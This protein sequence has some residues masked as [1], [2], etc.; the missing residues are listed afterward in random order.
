MV[1]L[2][3]ASPAELDIIQ[4]KT[5][6]NLIQEGVTAE[7]GGIN[8]GEA[9]SMEQVDLRMYLVTESDQNAK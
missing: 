5:A 2:S 3:P 8:V 9:W 1:L 6:S 4:L 7:S